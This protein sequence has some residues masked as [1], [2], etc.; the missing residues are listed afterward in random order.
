MP[1][2]FGAGIALRPSCR[3]AHQ[4]E[5]DHARGRLHGD[6]AVRAACVVG[7]QES[8]RRPALNRDVRERCVVVTLTH[9]VQCRRTGVDREPVP[10]RRATPTARLPPVEID[11][12]NIWHFCSRIQ[13]ARGNGRIGQSTRIP[14]PRIRI[15]T[16]ARRH[17]RHHRRLRR[18]LH[19]GPTP[20]T[21]ARTGEHSGNNAYPAHLRT[22]PADAGRYR[23]P[24]LVGQTVP[25]GTN[26]GNQIGRVASAK[27]N[28]RGDS[29]D[30]DSP[31]MSIN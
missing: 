1:L 13:P 18:D 20:R 10:V 9:V 4:P 27:S 24:A 5:H 14:D 19:R 21:R 22:L 3:A 28:F 12:G 31:L 17:R 15:S 23:L 29:W 11:A 26:P 16:G 6:A 30:S 7:I 2:H 25:L 8:K